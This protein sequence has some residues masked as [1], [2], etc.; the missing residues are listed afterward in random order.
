MGSIFVVKVF[1][2]LDWWK[3]KF[4]VGDAHNEDD[5]ISKDVGG[6]VIHDFDQL[7]DV[8][9]IGSVTIVGADITVLFVELDLAEVNTLWEGFRDGSHEFELVDTRVLSSVVDDD[10]KNEPDGRE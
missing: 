5:L 3:V 10:D 9:R 1:S 6:V 8:E 7:K 4:F 2:E